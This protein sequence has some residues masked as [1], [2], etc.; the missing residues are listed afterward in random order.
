MWVIVRPQAESRTMTYGAFL[1]FGNSLG[2]GDP[3]FCKGEPR[4]A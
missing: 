2:G 3:D 1:D 4:G